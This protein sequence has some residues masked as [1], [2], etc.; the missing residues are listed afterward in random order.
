MRATALLIN[1]FLSP[2]E[3]GGGGWHGSRHKA[4]QVGFRALKRNW[5]LLGEVMVLMV[6]EPSGGLGSFHWMVKGMYPKNTC[7]K[8]LTSR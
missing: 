4:G 7:T 1:G 2:H 3:V 8:G 6:T 5:M